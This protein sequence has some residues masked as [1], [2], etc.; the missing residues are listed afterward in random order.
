MRCPVALLIWLNRIFSA[1][2]V[3]GYSRMGHDT[4][5]RRHK[6][7]STQ[8]LHESRGPTA[9]SRRAF[10]SLRPEERGHLAIP[11]MIG[12]VNKSC[13]LLFG[14]WLNPFRG[15]VRSRSALRS[16]LYFVIH[17]SHVVK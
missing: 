16:R 10:S 7:F 9:T 15:S 5:E 8:M 13:Y 2:E 4:R 3:A 6:A 14:R 1:S 12:E 17:L 11:P